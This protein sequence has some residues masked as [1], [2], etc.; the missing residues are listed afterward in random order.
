MVEKSVAVFTDNREKW[1]ILCVGK[2]KAT[3]FRSKRGINTKQKQVKTKRNTV[4]SIVN[5]KQDGNNKMKYFNVYTE[6][7][8][9]QKLRCILCTG[10]AKQN[11]EENRGFA[12]HVK[13][14]KARQY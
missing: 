13:S 10:N 5:I 4:K 8:S 9:F 3:K 14:K 7:Q 12:Y 6:D 1:L 2:G 11:D